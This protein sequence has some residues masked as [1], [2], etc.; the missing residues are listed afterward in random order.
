MAWIEVLHIQ[1]VHVLGHEGPMDKSP[2]R[3]IYQFS[4]GDVVESIHFGALAVV[5]SS[6]ELMAHYGDPQGT[7]FLRS[8]AK[9]FQA[10]PFI[11]RGGADH[12]NLTDQEIAIMCASHSGSEEHIQVLQA[13]QRK[14]GIS[15]TD[16]KCGTH[17]PYHTPTRQKLEE[18]GVS[19]SANHHNCSGKHTGMI[20]HAILIGATIDTYLEPE[21]PVQQR[22]LETIT[23]MCS[24]EP[25]QV[26]LGTDG[27]SVPTF[28]MP[29]YHA[30]WGWA[31]LVD[32]GKSP[33]NLHMGCRRIT[34]TMAT[35]PLMVAGPDRFDTQ[36]MQVTEGKII[37]KSGAEAFQG[38]GITPGIL[39]D[40]S[41][42]IG[43]ALKISDGDRGKRVKAPVALEILHQLDAITNQELDQLKKY[44]PVKERT[45]HRDILVG[46]GKPTFTLSPE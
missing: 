24:L 22:I 46:H 4:R 26:E 31:K 30:A 5:T 21:H 23:Q 14:I 43:I 45:N 1:A 19:P 17:P 39:S 15:E 41:P 28:A 12:F 3:P 25:D 8:T 34:E 6:G 35:H 40:S 13:L 7:T 27:C 36:L 20:A 18:N 2:Y 42:G 16:L 11:A 9:P 33:R 32:P 38:L 37:A 10:L 29:L 44:A